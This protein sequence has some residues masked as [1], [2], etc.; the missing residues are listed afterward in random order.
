MFTIKLG[1]LFIF[2]KNIGNEIQK[3]KYSVNY[4]KN[5][6]INMFNRIENMTDE[7]NSKIAYIFE[8]KNINRKS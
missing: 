7:N 8:Y 4:S 3:A 5:N 1:N 2:N 6:Y